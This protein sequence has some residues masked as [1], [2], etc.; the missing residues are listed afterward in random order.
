MTQIDTSLTEVYKNLSRLRK[1]Q[2]IRSDMSGLIFTLSIEASLAYVKKQNK[3]AYQM[4]HYFA[5]CPSGLT[6]QD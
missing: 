4:L 1:Q 5:L 3:D 2:G 6:R